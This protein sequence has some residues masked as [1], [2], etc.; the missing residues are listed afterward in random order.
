MVSFL[1]LQEGENPGRGDSCFPKT[2]RGGVTM[3]LPFWLDLLGTVLIQGQVVT[4]VKLSPAAP[5]SVAPFTLGPCNILLPPSV[6][7]ET[8]S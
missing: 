3:G 1:A 5:Y 2:S 8:P 7:P 6:P 4:L